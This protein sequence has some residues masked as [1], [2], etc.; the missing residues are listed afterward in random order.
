MKEWFA[1][2]ILGLPELASSNGR[3]VDDL[4]V[5]L[6]WLML[7][8]FV[9][10]IAYFGYVLWRFNASRHPKA[11]Y[12]GAKSHVPS[13]VEVFIVVVEA[14]LLIFIAVPIWAKT[15]SK[16]PSPA[17]ATVVQIVA[18]QFAWNVRY[19]GPDGIFGHQDMK[20]VASD[21][22]FGVDPTDPNGKDDIQL[23]NEI[24]VP[25]NKPVL[26]YLSSKDVIHSLKL[27]AMRLTQD[28]IPG[29]RIPCTFT[30]TKIGRYQ[31]ECAQLCG[32][33]HASMAGGFVVVES[34]EDFTKWINSKSASPA[35]TSFE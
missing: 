26:I 24:H 32:N 1:H 13:Y 31:I 23:L 35:A 25:I 15:V 28:A 17:D 16:F 3:P 29:L 18:Q 20:F 19:A 5:Y 9:G 2:K 27:V 7:A 12:E 22:V 21:N 10:W 34:Q 8:L 6:H 4:M 33:G 30:P 11:Q 14:V